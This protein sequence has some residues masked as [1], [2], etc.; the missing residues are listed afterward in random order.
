[1]NTGPDAGR[2]WRINVR[3]R[4]Q[5]RHQGEDPDSKKHR[6]SK[7]AQ[8][9]QTRPKTESQVNRQERPGSKSGG[10]VKI[11]YRTM[12]QAEP[13]QKHRGGVKTKASGQKQVV[14][15]IISAKALSP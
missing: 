7:R 14:D 9:P 6:R 15:M 12:I 1:M 3:R 2:S 10:F 4:I 8:K 11:G 5:R 13:T